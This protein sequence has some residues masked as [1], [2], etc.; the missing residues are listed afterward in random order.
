MVLGAMLISGSGREFAGRRDGTNR[1]YANA[2]AATLPT[3]T[4]D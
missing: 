3:S 1:R 2:V 4:A